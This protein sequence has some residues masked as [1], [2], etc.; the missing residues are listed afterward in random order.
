MIT[1]NE[2]GRVHDDTQ[3]PSPIPW[4]AAERAQHTAL[5]TR[6]AANTR[7]LTRWFLAG[8][9]MPVLLV[10]VYGWEQYRNA[11]VVS[12]SP[13][14]TLQ[15]LRPVQQPAGFKPVVLVLKTSTDF[16][17]LHDPLNLPL[18]AQL[19]QERRASGRTYVCDAQRTQCAQV[20]RSFSPG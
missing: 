12:S 2:E 17:A 19:M 7:S 8:L 5:Q 10:T 6:L 20:A 16:V 3:T 11:Q 15:D 13:I 4:R 18:G 1:M 9:A 14:G